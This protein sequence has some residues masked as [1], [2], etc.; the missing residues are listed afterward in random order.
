LDGIP[1]HLLTFD[2]QSNAAYTVA[3]ESIVTE[4]N[5][6]ETQTTKG[7]SIKF[8]AIAGRTENNAVLT[9][10]ALLSPLPDE[11]PVAGEHTLDFLKEAGFAD[12]LLIDLSSAGSAIESGSWKVATVM[13][14]AVIEALLVWGLSKTNQNRLDNAMTSAQGDKRLANLKR[15]ECDLVDVFTLKKNL[16]AIPIVDWGLRDLIIVAHAAG[17]I[18]AQ[19]AVDANRARNYRNLIHPGRSQR[20]NSR[21]DRASAMICYGAAH[22]T[23][24]QLRSAIAAG[25]VVI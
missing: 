15:D 6:F 17:L 9:L 8:G 11:A 23:I 22:K 3:R 20:E 16:K 25:I 1:S 19:S 14:G 2:R 7:N 5:Y 4:L 12:S 21:A 18:D 24:E 10:R 13:A